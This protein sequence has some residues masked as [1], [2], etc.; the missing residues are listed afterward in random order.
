MASVEGGVNEWLK[1]H[2]QASGWM[3]GRME[4]SSD[5]D[6]ALCRCPILHLCNASKHQCHAI[7][8]G[9][10][11][12]SRYLQRTSVIGPWKDNKLNSNCKKRKRKMYKLSILLIIF[13]LCLFVCLQSIG[14]GSLWCIDP[15]YRQNLIQAL[16]KTPYHPHA[17]V[18]S[19]PP[20]SPQA[21]QR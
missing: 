8:S 2:E 18:Y 7:Q 19:T 13:S 4:R 1:P 6:G 12:S 3:D 17:Q 16:K 21:Y 5:S 15:E 14:K 11:P 10:C 9:T 20:T